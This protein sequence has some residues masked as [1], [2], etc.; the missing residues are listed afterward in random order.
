MFYEGRRE[1]LIAKKLQESRDFCFWNGWIAATG[2]IS[3]K[4]GDGADLSNDVWGHRR[5]QKQIL[6][7][8]QGLRWQQG[9][10]REK[11]MKESG[12]SGS[13]LRFATVASVRTMDRISESTEKGLRFW[14]TRSEVSKIIL[15]RVLCLILIASK[16]SQVAKDMGC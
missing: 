5:Q 12:N 10:S 3:R 11:G 13:P 7:K 2:Q 16:L 1:S 4:T 14:G 6:E 8:A 15:S 9:K